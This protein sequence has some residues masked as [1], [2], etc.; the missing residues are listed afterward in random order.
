M[1][2]LGPGRMDAITRPLAPRSRAF[3]A[4]AKFRP[5]VFAFGSGPFART[6]RGGE[7][8]FRM[9]KPYERAKFRRIRSKIQLYYHLW[10]AEGPS[11]RPIW[12]RA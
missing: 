3:R 4:E 5:I 11:G 12:R 10:R 2:R 9:K 8:V 6:G 7:P 1:S